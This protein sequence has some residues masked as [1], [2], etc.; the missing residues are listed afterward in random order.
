M[1]R[2]LATVLFVDLVDS[3]ALV[4][5]ADPEVVRRRVSSFFDQVS[6]CIVTHGGTVEKFAGD[7]VMAAFGVPLAHEDDAERAVRAGLATLDKVKELGLQARVGIESGEVVADESESTFATG[8]AVNLASRLQVYAGPNEIVVGP[9]AASLLR[10]RVEL[11]PIGELDLRGWREL[12]AAHRVVCAV[13]LSEPLRNLSAPL[14]GR[15]SELELLQNT[16]E[17]T[18]RDKRAA[19]FTIYG[20]PGVGKSRLAHEFVA[21]LEGATV[22]T[23]RCLPYGEGVTY[24]PLAE[25]V[26][27]S[28]GITDDDPLDEAQKKLRACC[29]DEAV[30]DLLGLAV[31]VLEAVEGER[32]QQEIAWAARAWAEQL[33]AAQPLVLVFEDVHWGEEPLL[34]LLEHLASSVREAPLLIVCLARPELLDVRPRWG[35]GRVRATTLELEP[36]QAEE[37]ALL[38]AA[39]TSELEV[40]VDAQTVLAKTEG[41]PL[42]ME[43]TVRMLAERRPGGGTERIPDTLQA[44]IAARIDRLP[45]APRVVLQRASVMGRIFM[46]GA[47]S[48]LTPELD[49]V[50]DALDELLIR[51]LVVREVRATISGERAYKF[52]HVLI[53]EVAYGGLSKTSRADL[54]HAFAEWLG[55]RAGDEL[56]EIRAFHLDQA[57][58]L[59]AELDGSAPAE[60]REEA[61]EVLTKAGRRALSRESFRS[62]RKLLLRAVELAP[63]LER[64]YFAGRA[65]WR[66]ADFPAVLVEMS[67]VASDAEQA[68]ETRVQ[69]RALTALAEAVLQ[70]RA[71]AVTAR[72]L[73][74]Q[75]VEVLADAEP[76]VRFEP[77][78]IAS[79]VA[80]W[81]GDYEEFE[82]WAKAALAAAREADRKDL[83]AL[84]IH[85]LV[86][87]YV[88]RLEVAEAA[89]LLLRAMELADQSGSLLSRASALSVKGWVELVSERFAEAEDDYSAARELFIELGNSTREAV[90]TMMVGR[91]AFAQGDVDRA[92]K[93]LRDAVRALKGIGDRG[94]LCEAQRALAMVLVEQG[95]LDEAE[96]FALEAR[97]TVG[98][99]D[100]V[101][102]SST[103]LGL[104]VVRAAQNRDAEA[105]KLMLE[106]VE[107]FDL[108]EL[109]ALEHGALRHL[110]EFLRSR[111]REDEAVAYEA[112]RSALSPSSTVPIV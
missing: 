7:A 29:E 31:G 81:F 25:M 26:K 20:D 17:R 42:F 14:V 45:A 54:H 12:V 84:V 37:S 111:G 57:T 47:L 93:L 109:H 40:P 103:K 28:S 66:L 83:E 94:S 78:W 27:S 39:L 38:V 82:R 96:R 67:E 80:S 55:E 72:R 99:E 36:L 98:P 1:E 60:L 21:G 68:G 41:N 105:E 53:R 89:P 24:W 90:M 104:G 44:L 2:K 19:L 75:A 79:Q 58:H 71:D 43:E 52:K 95:A 6:R 85:G 97:E 8:E 77:L 30:A 87:A 11:E 74:A 112:R 62:A 34:E 101:S 106:A 102:V 5:D 23:G 110:A 69:G 107:G 35:G 49:D 22:L 86:S 70:H 63:T 65:A 51:D 4:S 3:T 88:L 18:V 61:A 73:V 76:D 9:G 33:A 64:R 15:E 48:K 32:A 59:L 108:Y 13:E 10:G 92:E 46:S 16:H 91:A 56:L 100:R 50:E